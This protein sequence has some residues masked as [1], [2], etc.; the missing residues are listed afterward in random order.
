MILLIVTLLYI[1]HKKEIE[2]MTSKKEL[3]DFYKERLATNERWALRALERIAMRQTEYE[4]EN[5]LT[6]ESNKVGF[7]GPDA[8]ILTSFYRVVKK[9][10]S[11]TPGQKA[12]LF[13]KIPKY[14][15]Q[16][17]NISLLEGKLIKEGRTYKFART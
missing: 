2:K 7:S 16:L 4:L 10:Y 13:R 14:A 11:L 5:D 9:G 1:I 6:N 3:V 17:V 12:V 15:G 8:E